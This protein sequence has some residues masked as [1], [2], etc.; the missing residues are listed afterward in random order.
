[1]ANDDGHEALLI[2]GEGL[3][4]YQAPPAANARQQ[5]ELQDS[6]MSGGDRK[7]T[8]DQVVEDLLA[9][10]LI[11]AETAKDLLRRCAGAKKDGL[12]LLE[13]IAE[14]HPMS[15]QVPLRQLDLE[16]LTVWLAG[17]CG[18]P[19]LR[20]DPLKIDVA[21]IGELTTIAYA[22]WNQILPV[23][24]TPE[25][26]VFATCEPYLTD[27]MAEL[28]QVLKRRIE[29]VVANPRDIER[30]RREFFYDEQEPQLFDAIRELLPNYTNERLESTTFFSTFIPET[31]RVIRCDKRY[32]KCI[33]IFR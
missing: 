27:W 16:A 13:R 30:F 24:L 6:A 29:R 22:T 31:N 21:T 1:M 12:H 26:A 8:L 33:I 11:T 18:L 20:I 4:G 32:R 17:R 19:Y 23:A 3:L 2:P 28:Q 7:L 9:D 5:L 14:Q 10:G 15:A 25:K